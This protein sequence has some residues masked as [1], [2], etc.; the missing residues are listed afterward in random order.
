MHNASNYAIGAIFSWRLNNVIHA[1]YNT[2]KTLYENQKNYTTKKKKE[3]LVVLH[4]LEKLR[5]Y[6]MGAKVTVHTNHIRLKYLLEKKDVKPRF[7]QSVLLLKKF[8]MEIRDK[9]G[10]KNVI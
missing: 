4:A 9:R 10:S 8:N 6:L 7:I 3:L 5:T 2:S 1:I